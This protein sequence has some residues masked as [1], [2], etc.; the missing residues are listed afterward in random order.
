VSLGNIHMGDVTRSSK[1]GAYENAD[2]QHEQILSHLVLEA[3]EGITRR[4]KSHLSDK[5]GLAR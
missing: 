2:F 5:D 3:F 4:E 1:R